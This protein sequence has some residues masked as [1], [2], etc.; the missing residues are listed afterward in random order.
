M[1]RWPWGAWAGAGE[2]FH[3][4]NSRFRRC[5]LACG[6]KHAVDGPCSRWR[7]CF[8]CRPGI[9][10]PPGTR[11][12]GGRGRR[13]KKTAGLPRGGT[14]G[15]ASAFGSAGGEPIRKGAKLTTAP[16]NHCVTDPGQSGTYYSIPEL[17]V[18]STPFPRNIG[19][20][21][22]FFCVWCGV[23]WGRMGGW[24]S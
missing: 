8:R 2:Q 15:S 9:P 7:S 5:C 23:V 18:P 6:P 20:N 1:R 19:Q 4:G 22:N 3:Q 12:R 21:S 24:C 11:G 14:T 10:R 17:R 16:D 13:G